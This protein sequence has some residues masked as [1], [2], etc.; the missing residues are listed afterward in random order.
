MHLKGRI[1]FIQGLVIID[2][3]SCTNMVSSILMSKMNMDTK[4]YPKPYKLQWLSEGEEVQVKQQ[5]KV[6]FSIW[7]YQDKIL[8]DV[9]PIEAKHILFRRP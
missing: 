7:K 5:A 6:S 2:G 3:G 4:P 1:F 9:V 8:C